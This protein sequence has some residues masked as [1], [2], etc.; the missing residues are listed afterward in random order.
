MMASE[1]YIKPIRW[2]FDTVEI[3]PVERSGRDMAAMR[4]AIRAWKAD[5]S[6]GCSRK[7]RLKRPGN[8]CHSKT[9]SGCLLLSGAP[10]YPAYLD[11][12][13]RGSE[14]IQVFVKS[15]TCSLTFG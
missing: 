5:A 3:I 13:Q 15:N 9:A 4:A 8:F 10:V 2:F 12:T 11:G 14:M 7:G 1:Y 6:W